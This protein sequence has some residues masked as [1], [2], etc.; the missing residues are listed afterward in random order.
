MSYK[1]IFQ[2][3]GLIA[4]LNLLTACTV[5]DLDADGNPIIPKNPNAAVSFADFT[6][7]EVAD[8]LWEPKVFPE[9]T[10]EFTPWE[11][12]KSQLDAQQIDTKQSFFVRL[13]GTIESVDLGKMRGAITIKVGDT[14]IDLQVGRIIK[15]NAIRDAS[16]YVLFDDFK[17]QIRFAQI[18]REFNNRAMAS[19]GEPDSSWVGEKATVIAAITIDQNTISDAVPIQIT[20]GGK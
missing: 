5:T 9:A 16:K 3:I 8:Q 6:L 20:R 4:C 2:F 13:D 14:N 19:V 12:I 11:S 17:N 1:K 18:S 10:Q 15:G 7:S